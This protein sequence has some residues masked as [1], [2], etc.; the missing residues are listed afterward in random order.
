VDPGGD[1]P[2]DDGTVTAEPEPTD[3]PPVEVTE[4]PTEEPTDEPTGEPGPEATGDP[5]PTG[6]PEPTLD[7]EPT[8]E[9]DPSGD[10]E[11]TDGPMWV[12]TGVLAFTGG[13]GGV[14]K[15]TTTLAVPDALPRTGAPVGTLAAT[16]LLMIVG[17]AG[18]VVLARRRT[19]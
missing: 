10:P 2:T 12:C 17:G 3:E 9:P 18:S 14:E 8:G 11:P 7:P 13:E 1:T 19:G 16:G 5:D 6:D 15:D 4:E